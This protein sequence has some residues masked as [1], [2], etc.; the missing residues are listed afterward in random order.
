MRLFPR[1]LALALLASAFTTAHAQQQTRFGVGVALSTSGLDDSAELVDAALNPAGIYVPI[2]F[3]G[4]RIEPEIGF[5]TFSAEDDQDEGGGTESLSTV[6]ATIGLFGT[7]DRD[8][9]LFYYGG[10]LGATFN[11]SDRESGQFDSSTSST[12][13]L[14]AP[15]IG[16]EHFLSSHLSVGAE[17]QIAILSFGDVEVENNGQDDTFEQDQ[18]LIRTRGLF[19]ARF[20]F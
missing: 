9:T 12:N 19:F 17:A 7:L 6:Q 3:D 18:T 4:F 11:R 20:H 5:F 14:I 2:T 10:R 1:L 16:A 13:L 8:A 15:A